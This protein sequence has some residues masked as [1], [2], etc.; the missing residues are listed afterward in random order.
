VQR[1]RLSFQISVLM[2]LLS[3]VVM[4]AALSEIYIWKDSEGITTFSDNPSIAPDPAKVDLWSER[5][6]V[7]AVSERDLSGVDSEGTLEEPQGNVTQGE[8]AIQLARELGLGENLGPKE[9]AQILSDI[10][11]APILGNW[12]LDKALTPDL[13][14]RLRTLTVAAAQMQWITIK[15]EQALMA[16]DTTSALLGVDIPLVE[17]KEAPE[18]SQPLVDIPPLVYISP[19]PPLISSYY[20]WIPFSSGFLWQG[21]IIHGIFTLQRPHLNA[22]FFNGHHFVFQ[23][24]FVQRHLTNYFVEHTAEP[25]H[26]VGHR[27]R[28]HHVRDHHPNRDIGRGEGSRDHVNQHNRSSSSD[29][30]FSSTHI[31]PHREGSKNNVHSRRLHLPGTRIREHSLSHKKLETQHPS[32][33]FIPESPSTPKRPSHLPS[34]HAGPDHKVHSF[35]SRSF[36]KKH[37][38]RGK[39]RNTRWGHKKQISRHGLGHFNTTTA[40]HGH[41]R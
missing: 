39:H 23:P 25:L 13:T 40:R 31:L 41:G 18:S 14:S 35:S 16:F 2:V 8:F 26:H 12:E 38:A 11:I 32:G 4:E 33:H 15:P 20:S 5:T 19:P 36:S 29:S 9:A 6:S 27:R 17:D 1:I 34:L 7:G 30:G 22:H 37:I 28:E 10:R 3:I 24:H 21:A